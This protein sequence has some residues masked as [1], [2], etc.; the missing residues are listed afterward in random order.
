MNGKKCIGI[1]GAIIICISF[2]SAQHPDWE[3]EKMIGRN[4]EQGHATYVP[5]AD[6]DQALKG[7]AE[8]SPLYRSLNGDWKFNWVKQPSERP[9]KFYEQN[10]DVSKWKTIPVPSNWQLHGYGKPLY[11]NVRYPFKKNPPL[12][13][14]EV[15]ENWTKASLPNPVG[16]YRREFEIP[17]DWKEK[18]VFLHFAGVQSAMYVWVNGKKVG[19]SQGSMT[20]A[21]F[22]ITPYLKPGKNMVD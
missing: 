7:V 19:Y 12:I 20:P 11:V 6:A 14:G 9:V 10:Y 1:I 4:K 8:A 17:A 22:N 5:F 3:N 2:V 15:P 18:A 16:S 21:E 13:M